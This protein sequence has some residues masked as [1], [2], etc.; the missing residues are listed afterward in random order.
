M[1]YC[2]KFVLNLMNIC[3]LCL[4]ENYLKESHLIPSRFCYKKIKS[5]GKN[6]IYIGEDKTF[7]TSKE[8]KAYLLCDKCEQRFGIKENIISRNLIQHDKSFPLQDKVKKL[9]L[10][11]ETDNGEAFEGIEIKELC[12]DLGY[13]ASSVFW[14]SSVHEWIYLICSPKKHAWFSIRGRLSFLFIRKI[15]LSR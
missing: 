15:E 12:N 7:S 4:T 3:A 10:I 8:I 5:E 11:C 9:K 6:P 13:F 14:R 1:K 2:P